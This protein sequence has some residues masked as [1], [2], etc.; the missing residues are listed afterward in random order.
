MAA[1]AVFLALSGCKTSTPPKKSTDLTVFAAASLKDVFDKVAKAFE[2]KYPAHVVY[3]FAGS[4]HLALQI[5]QGA[6]CDVFASADQ[7]QMKMAQVSGRISP[8]NVLTFAM[9]RLVVVATKKAGVHKIQ[10]LARK[11][12]KIVLAD[13]K[14]PAGSYT[15]DMLDK[16]GAAFKKAVLANVASYEQDVRSVLAKVQ[17]GEADAGV[18]YATDYAVSHD[19]EK[20]ELPGKYSTT[21]EYQIAPLTGPNQELA[22]DF[23]SFVESPDGQQIFTNEGFV[24]L[25]K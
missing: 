3:S 17:L 8:Q 6:P 20:I 11:G 2:T 15:S 5:N 10:D 16:G 9:N 13:S 7:M 22:S 21:T 4:Q 12:L 24:T 18:V 25:T 1:F 14:V 19:L 23:V